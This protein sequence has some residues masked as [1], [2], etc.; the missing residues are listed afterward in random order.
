MEQEFRNSLKFSAI[1]EM[2]IELIFLKRFIRQRHLQIPMSG[3]TAQRDNLQ[4]VKFEEMPCWV[5]KF[6]QGESVVVNN[7][8][9]ICHTM[10]LEYELLKMKAI[11]SVVVLP[12][13]HGSYLTGFL[14]LDNPYIQEN[15]NFIFFLD[16]I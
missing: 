15:E 7:I 2:Q 13:F 3:I 9:D 1:M 5:K 8:E 10:P 14:G 16:L 4:D 12:L 6:R 11:K